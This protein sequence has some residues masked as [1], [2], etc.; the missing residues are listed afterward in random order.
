MDI[1]ETAKRISDFI[2]GDYTAESIAS[3]MNKQIDLHLQTFGSEEVFGEIVPEQLRSDL[4]LIRGNE[5]DMAD[6]LDSVE[7]KFLRIG[8][9]SDYAGTY[10]KEA[11]SEFESYR[12][13]A[14][15][16]IKRAEALMNTEQ[17]LEQNDNM[18]DGVINNKA[19]SME[20]PGT[21][22][23]AEK[24]ADEA[25]HERIIKE[26]KENPELEKAKGFI[27]E[28][29]QSEYGSE[30][31]FSDLSSIGL[32]YTTI[33]YPEFLKEAGV[34]DYGK[35][36]EIQVDANLINKEII[37]YIDGDELFTE[38]F[39]SLADMNESL[40]ELD[41]NDLIHIGDAGWQK[42]ADREIDREAIAAIDA[43][44]AEFGA[45]GNR[46]FPRL[47]ETKED[48]LAERIDRLAYDMYRNKAESPLFPLNKNEIVNALETGNIEDI[49]IPLANMQGL[50]DEDKRHKVFNAV[51]E[52]SDRPV[53]LLTGQKI[54]EE[55]QDVL[56]RLDHGEYVKLEEI[57]QIP[58][59]QLAEMKKSASP[60]EVT[61]SKEEIIAATEK[62]SQF[63]SADIDEKGKVTYNGDVGK[64]ARL[65]IIIGL[66]ASGKSSA[67]LDDISKEF[68]SKLID[69]DEAK[70]MFKEF[71]HGW[72]A[73]AVHRDSQKVE[74]ATFI[75]AIRNHENIVLPKVGS[76][77]DDLIKQYM[78]LAKKEGYK[79]NIHYVELEREKSL[80]RMLR[81][82]IN[83]GRYLEPKLI[84]KYD[85][86]IDGNKIAQT[87]DKF[88]TDP[89]Y[90]KYID[91]F[92]RWNNDVNKGEK[93]IL[94]EA[95]N[96]SGEYIENA[97][98]QEKGEEHNGRTENGFK[99]STSRKHADNITSDGRNR[100][101]S[102]Q[103]S[104]TGRGSDAESGREQNDNGRDC[105]SDKSVL[106]GMKEQL[107]DSVFDYLNEQASSPRKQQPILG[108]S[109]QITISISSKLVSEPFR[110]KDGKEYVRVKIPNEDRN[111]KSPWASIVITPEQVSKFED[112]GRAEI[113]M[114]ADGYSTLTKSEYK[115]NDENGKAVFEQS[116]TKVA[117][118]ELKKRIEHTEPK[119][120]HN[121]L[122]LNRTK[123]DEI[124][125][126]KDKAKE[127]KKSMNRNNSGID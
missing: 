69:S 121:A 7:K 40:E 65:D 18:I 31:N 73:G 82:F 117:N 25:E 108:Y 63:G 125:K 127:Q 97:R 71:N 115:G 11:I 114:K 53:M 29:T 94:I 99:E 89:D 41:F 51:C 112:T 57:M 58:E 35:E 123:A 36:F 113:G 87:Y 14:N 3:I 43:Q 33:D 22:D 4:D 92:S 67:I 81:R 68:K 77:A 9:D 119:N 56:N 103:S 60:E 105:G 37:T 104:F 12:G 50:V 122:K 44:E 45:D 30:P 10:L 95:E 64:D 54:G 110:A 100:G 16:D 20:I 15:E 72:G 28:F 111:D 49:T 79:V 96:L 2:G 23:E 126:Q 47:N 70:K 32:A 42:I 84:D 116:K 102:R 90:S 1:N 17:S 5:R 88:K 6:V 62:M 26:M 46:I 66:P 91:G 48:T 120:I 59:I 55:M 106:R 38:K 27:S 52:Y 101:E 124:N 80:G 8:M 83:Q 98:T 118:A 93:P 86:E 21:Y 34:T 13:Y 109:S 107:P 75:K 39:D 74:Q 78:A 19:N 24:E 76:N 85:N 61:H